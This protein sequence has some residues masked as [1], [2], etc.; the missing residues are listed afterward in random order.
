MWCDNEPE[1]DL[2][3]PGQ[4]SN[5]DSSFRDT[6][7]I[8]SHLC[9]EDEDEDHACFDDHVSDDSS[10]DS[11]DDG[12]WQRI[13]DNDGGPIPIPFTATQ[14][15]HHIPPN[16]DRPIDDFNLIFTNTL[17]DNIVEE[18]NRYSTQCIETREEYLANH[19][20]SR[21]HQWISQGHT[22]NQEI[23][24]FLGVLFNM[25]FIKKPTLESYWDITHQSLATHWFPK[26][27]NRN[28]FQLLLKFLHFN[29]NSQLDENSDN[30]LFKIQ[31]L[32]DHFQTAF[33]SYFHLDQNFSLD[34]S[35]VR[36]KGLTPRL[37]QYMP[38]K[39][40]ARLG[41]KVWCVCDVKTGYTCSFEIHEG[42]T[43]SPVNNNIGTTHTTVIRLLSQAG[44]CNKGHKVGF[45]NFFSSPALF[46]DLHHC[47]IT[48]TGTV[49]EN[50]VGLPAT[51][52]NT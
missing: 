7:S 4:L 25:G 33:T 48:A 30:V 2:D 13:R 27:F 8:V 19:P 20:Q 34:E 23:Q 14:G 32:T 21:T 24:A 16:T 44:L 45:D 15:L 12:V 1:P 40:H 41:I 29:D 11:A 10:E 52:S 5:Q 28:R 47:A 37:H 26:H 36:F 39:H 43:R 17:I 46:F 35:M 31:P 6:A 18:T 50:R 38:N 51:M 22:Y 9:S 49:R 3:D 42:K